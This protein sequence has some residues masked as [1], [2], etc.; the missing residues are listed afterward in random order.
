[1]KTKQQE[2]EAAE[3][4]GHLCQVL[5]SLLCCWKVLLLVVLVLVLICL[6]LNRLRDCQCALGR[7]RVPDRGMTWCRRWQQL[8]SPTSRNCRVVHRQIYFT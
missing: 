3:C 4:G 2:S 5:L 8:R 1:M 6:I 7:D